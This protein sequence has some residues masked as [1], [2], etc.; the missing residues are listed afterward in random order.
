MHG[1]EVKDF[2]YFP[3]VAF[4]NRS[5]HQNN[6]CDFFCLND[7]AQN[8]NLSQLNQ[9][10]PPAKKAKLGEQ[11]FL[12]KEDDE[13]QYIACSKHFLVEE[14]IA[15]QEKLKHWWEVN[16]ERQHRENNANASVNPSAHSL[17]NRLLTVSSMAF[18]RV[19]R[20]LSRENPDSMLLFL[21]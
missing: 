21:R 4:P 20:L 3:S 15:D 13:I 6:G 16:C 12:F 2:W 18:T 8:Q 5:F 19:P 17:K 9:S 10:L 1:A 14:H 7:Q 11:A